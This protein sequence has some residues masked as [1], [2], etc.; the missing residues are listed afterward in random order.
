MEVEVGRDLQTQLQLVLIPPFHPQGI[1]LYPACDVKTLGGK[2]L[3]LEHPLWR[4]HQLSS[5]TIGD[6][7]AQSLQSL[8]FTQ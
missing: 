3:S 2:P 5:S 6:L 4:V 7:H 1:S 8:L